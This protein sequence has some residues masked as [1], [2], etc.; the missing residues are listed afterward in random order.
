MLLAPAPPA[1]SSILGPGGTA[2]VAGAALRSRGTSFTSKVF[3]SGIHCS[4]SPST[5]FTL[6]PD[7]RRARPVAASTTHSSTALAVVLVNAT[8]VPAAFQL[9][10][11]MRAAAGR[12]TFFSALSVSLRRLSPIE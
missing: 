2:G 12:V 11:P 10:P 7:S 9:T 4:P 6:T 1:L 8:R 5:L 3:P